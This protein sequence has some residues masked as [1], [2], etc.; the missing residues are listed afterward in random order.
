[1][2]TVPSMAETDAATQRMG[3]RIRR[4]RVARGL[5][6]NDFAALT[7]RGK[8]HLSRIENG[9][10]PNLPVSTLRILAKALKVSPGRIV[11]DRAA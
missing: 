10:I 7:G 2:A 9:I 1:L 4:L 5:S 3:R 6:L 11:N 8:G